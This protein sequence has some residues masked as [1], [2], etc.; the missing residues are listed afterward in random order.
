MLCKLIAKSYLDYHGFVI[1]YN[2][3]SLSYSA[4]YLSFMLENLGHC[5]CMVLTLDIGIN[6]VNWNIFKK[7]EIKFIIYLFKNG[8]SNHQQKE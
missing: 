2:V 7:N 1:I 3:K 8:E 4:S 5:V 6:H